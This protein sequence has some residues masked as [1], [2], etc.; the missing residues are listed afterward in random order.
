[1]SLYDVQHDDTTDILRLGDSA[2]K[3]CERVQDAV[4]LLRKIS[5]PRL[6]RRRSRPARRSTAS[7]PTPTA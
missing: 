7:S 6:P 4:T 2:C 5:E 1:M 3:C